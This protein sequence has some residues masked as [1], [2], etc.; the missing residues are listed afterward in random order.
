MQFNAPFIHHDSH[1]R[2][3]RHHRKNVN[4]L[5]SRA[6]HPPLLRACAGFQNSKD[7]AQ[8]AAKMRRY[9]NPNNVANK[10]SS[11]TAHT[12]DTGE[13]SS[14]KTHKED[15]VP[16]NNDEVRH[17]LNW[18]F[19]GTEMNMGLFE[20]MNG[21]RLCLFQLYNSDWRRQYFRREASQLTAKSL[22]R[23]ESQARGPTREPDR[24]KRA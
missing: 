20:A 19:I 5:S 1:S 2:T 13:E 16:N 4:G 6:S 12:R 18:G 22:T 24:C 17:R 23:C 11:H 10:H 21:L 7:P 14:Y 3:K 9:G 15:T 8:N